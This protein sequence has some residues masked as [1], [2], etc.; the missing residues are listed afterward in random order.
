MPYSGADDANL[1]DNVKEMPA[2]KRKQWV[3]IWNKTYDN[4]MSDKIGGGG[5]NQK[6]CEGTAFKFANGAV[7]ETSMSDEKVKDAI[8]KATEFQDENKARQG[9][10]RS[11]IERAMNHFKISEEEAEEGLRTGKLK[12]P[13]RGEGQ[14]DIIVEQAYPPHPVVTSFEEMEVIDEARKKAAEIED[15][16]YTAQNLIGNIMS[17]PDI[18]D[19]PGKLENLMNSLIKRTKKLLGKKEADDKAATK[20]EDGIE[21][22]ASDYAVVPDP[23]KPS[24]WK[25]RLAEKSSGDFTVAQIAR[26][27]TAMQPGGFRGQRVEFA[28][29]DKEQAISRIRA[30]I[31]K[32]K[33]DK[34]QRENLEERLAKI[35]EVGNANS[36]KCFKDASG[37]W[38]WVSVVSN[39][40]KDRDGEIITGTAHK[41]FTEYLDKGGEYPEAW[42]WH[43]PGTRWGKADWADFVDGFLVVSGVVDAGKEAIAEALAQDEGL[44]VS[45]GYQY[46][47]NDKVKGV[48]NRYRMLE[49]SP[50]PMKVAANEWTSLE[51]IKR[52]VDM[53]AE[54]RLFLVE[55]MG[56][57]AVVRLEAGLAD[58]NKALQDAG[59]EWKEAEEKP[60]ILDAMVDMATK[61]IEGSPKL[62]EISDAMA[63]LNGR[64]AKLEKSD[65]EKV[66]AILVGAAP[67]EGYVA[68][69]AKDNKPSEEEVALKGQPDTGWFS[70][71]IGSTIKQG[72]N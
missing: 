22:K 2:D 18:E 47:S 39:H 13:P 63:A 71:M 45:H 43:T 17:N 58:F 66:A 57:D 46:T 5:G 24:T 64:M 48:I 23:E 35:K 30:T 54:K 4:C 38:R 31:G 62:K 15:L 36:F 55:K 50:L 16:T 37:N 60:G 33:P 53:N 20:T 29:G 41:E 67:K 68:S 49:M 1:P 32:A 72:G 61:A 52:E 8:Q 56:E 26:A 34:E 42:L 21:F 44:G 9:V 3:A 28:P 12:L 6:D 11:D 69:E 25:L 65:D 7:K 51:I 27:I 59:V 14:K 19:K 10:P 70:E 40:F